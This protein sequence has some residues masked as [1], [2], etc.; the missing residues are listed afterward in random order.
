[1]PCCCC[2]FRVSSKKEK[3]ASGLYSRS[4]G[5]LSSEK[6]IRLFSYAELRS[7]TNNFHRSNNIGRGGFGTVYK[8]AL[9]DGGGD[10]AVKVL[11]AHS[12]QGTTEFLTEID[13][14]ANV[15]HPNLVSLLGCCVEGRH[16]ILVYEHLRNGSLHGALLASAGDPARLTWGIRRGVCVGVARGL[17]FLHEEMASGPIVHR[18]IKASNVL[19][20]A[21]YGAKIGDFGLAKLFPDAATH[22]STRVAGTTGYLAPEYALYGHLTK[23]ADVYSYGVLLLETVTG[24]S[25]SRSLH[26][27]DEGD[28]VLVERVW[29]LYE[30]AN[31]REMIDPAME[32]GCNEEEAVRYMKVA[33]LCT[34]A[35]PQR[36]PSM[37]QVLEMLEREDV[38]VREKELTPPGYVVRDNKDSHSTSMLV[39]SHTLTELAPR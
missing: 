35:T 38:R 11:S 10:V 24:K 8:G 22:V 29:E 3:H 30:A 14:I 33:L 15:E 5:R 37:P 26:L 23:K 32:D 39:A 1:M 16:R 28:K 34:Q 36:R 25:S 20:D 21:G 13:V 12:R 4:M 2:C 18:D 7:A 9:R 17:A 6:K 31:L 19:L 27:S